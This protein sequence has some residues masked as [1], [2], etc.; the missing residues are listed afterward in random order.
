M[1]KPI[2]KGLLQRFDIHVTRGAVP[3]DLPDGAQLSYSQ[4]GEDAIID[5]IFRLRGVHSPSYIDIGA[6]D[7]FRLSNTAIFYR[8]GCRGINIEPNP[9]LIAN[10]LKTRSRD[11]NLGVGVGP[12]GLLD[13][14]VMEDPTLS[15]F[16]EEEARHLELNG[17]KVKKVTPIEVLPLTEI[18]DRHAKGVFPDLLTI[19]VEGFELE[20]LKSVDLK[21]GPKVM[22]IETAEYSTTG[23]GPKRFGLMLYVEGMGYE[24]YADTNL[25]SIYVRRDFWRV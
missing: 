19:D 20:I 18:I 21:Q 3:V 23:Q 1:L 10:F 17:R 7:P 8:R 15:T 11:V 24:L 25:N 9:A 12:R 16:S 13:F 22:C 14:Y 6:Y 5:Y 2:V 4:C